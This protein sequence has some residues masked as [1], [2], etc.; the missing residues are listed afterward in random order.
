MIIANPF[1]IGIA[2]IISSS[3]LSIY[4]IQ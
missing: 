1:L 4:V 2:S 3:E